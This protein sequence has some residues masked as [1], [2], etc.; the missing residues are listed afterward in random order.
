[1][2]KNS[3]VCVASPRGFATILV[4]YT[5]NMARCRRAKLVLRSSREGSGISPLPLQ[6]AFLPIALGQNFPHIIYTKQLCG[7]TQVHG[8]NFLNSLSLTSS[9]EDMSA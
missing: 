7:S 1:M 2:A 6:R 9:P 5:E 8:L 3:G 4:Y